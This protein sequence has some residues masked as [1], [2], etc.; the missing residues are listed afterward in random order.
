MSILYIVATPIGNLEDISLRALRVLGEVDFI[1][2][3]DTRVTGKLLA[4]FKIKTPTIS[5]HQHSDLKKIDYVLS[6]LE[7]GKDLALVTDAGTPGISDP[8]GKLVQAAIEKFGDEIKVESVPGPSAVTA[9]LSIS[10]IPTDKFV[11]M[12]FPPHK[13]GRQTFLAKILES[14]WP[15]VVYE[16]KHRIIKF[17]EELDYINQQIDKIKEINPKSQTPNPKQIPNPKSKKSKT[18]AVRKK[19][20]S[21]VVCRELSKMHETVYRGELKSIIEK[22]KSDPN[23]QKGEFVVIIGK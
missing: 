15:V 2:C 5:F 18:D 7:G 14:E 10:G 20:Q 21:V 22:I 6:L 1:L 23:A 9:A 11:F 13:K 17:L 8:G 12:G 4:H 19:V 3:E 16:S